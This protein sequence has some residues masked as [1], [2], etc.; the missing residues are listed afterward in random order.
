MPAGALL[1]EG[2]DTFL[3]GAR[4]DSAGESGSVP[5]H[6]S[7]RRFDDGSILR[8]VGNLHHCWGRGC[9]VGVSSRDADRDRTGAPAARLTL[10]VK[11]GLRV[12]LSLHLLQASALTKRCADVTAPLLADSPSGVSQRLLLLRRERRFVDGHLCGP[13]RLLIL[14]CSRN[15][16]LNHG[17]SEYRRVHTQTHATLSVGFGISA[18]KSRRIASGLTPARRASSALDI[19]WY[20]GIRMNT[21]GERLRFGSRLR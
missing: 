19:P 7:T 13:I 15:R 8:F 17:A 16:V 20:P 9:S 14:W 2:V 1:R 3:V 5:P 10:G 21:S 6:L 18:E 4:L 12:D 11:L